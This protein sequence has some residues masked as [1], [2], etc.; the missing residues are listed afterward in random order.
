MHRGQSSFNVG[1]Q[2]IWKS[3]SNR[4]W[5]GNSKNCCSVLPFLGWI[6]AFV[7]KTILIILE[8]TVNFFALDQSAKF[9]LD[10]SEAQN[11]VNLSKEVCWFL[12]K[13]AKRANIKCTDSNGTVSKKL[14]GLSAQVLIMCN[15]AGRFNISSAFHIPTRISLSFGFSKAMIF[16]TL[17]GSPEGVR[18]WFMNSK[19]R[20]S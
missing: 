2:P 6:C 1:R 14:R 10:F 4:R 5:G 19:S 18:F 12:G 16:N 3:K 9:T 15:A 20:E 7:P 17:F 8:S 13:A 11:V